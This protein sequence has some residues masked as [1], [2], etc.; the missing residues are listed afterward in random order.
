MRALCDEFNVIFIVDEVKTGFRFGLGGAQQVLG[1]DA[2]MATFGK[3][4]CNG[5]PGSVLVG[6]AAILDQVAETFIG[7][8]F[9]GDLASV[10][11]A[12]VV[13]DVLEQ[14][15]TLAHI[16][17]LG[18]KLIDGLEHVFAETGYP[19]RMR[20]FP[21]MPEVVQ[22]APDAN[23]RPVPVPWAGKV[24]TEWCAAMMRRGC[25]VTGHVW[26]VSGAHT[27]ADIE[28]TIAAGREAAHEAQEILGAI[29]AGT[30]EALTYEN[31]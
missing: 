15:D 28:H 22:T 5:L 7:A 4:M 24:M 2:D 16:H 14:T 31:I 18:Q 27:E 6:K 12:N 8:T 3:A 11:A 10:A 21:A 19:L 9:H 1:F 29:T 26:F 20:G 30:V 23:T 17:R 25:F 13:I